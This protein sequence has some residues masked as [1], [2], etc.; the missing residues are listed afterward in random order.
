MTSKLIV[1]MF[2]LN[3]NLGLVK[4]ELVYLDSNP[5]KLNV[6]ILLII[7]YNI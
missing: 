4:T 7:A 5:I 1:Y 2:I 6:K 3:I